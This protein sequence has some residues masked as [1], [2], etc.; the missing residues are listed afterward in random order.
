MTEYAVRGPGAA[1]VDL[2]KKLAAVALTSHRPNR[3]LDET[4]SD[5]DD[6]QTATLITAIAQ[7]AG[8]RTESRP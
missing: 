2:L 8:P 7:P 1:L 6:S 5:D 3:F 4:L